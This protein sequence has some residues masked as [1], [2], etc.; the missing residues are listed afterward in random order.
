MWRLRS[1]RPWTHAST[2]EWTA[3]PSIIFHIFEERIEYRPLFFVEDRLQSFVGF[4]L[5]RLNLRLIVVEEGLQFR[6]QFTPLFRPQRIDF[7]ARFPHYLPELPLL[8][9]AEIKHLLE[10]SS[11]WPGTSAEV[12]ASEIPSLL[13]QRFPQPQIR[14]SGSDDGAEK[15]YRN[16]DCQ[17]AWAFFHSEFP[18]CSSQLPNS[19]LCICER[20]VPRFAES[21]SSISF[22]YSE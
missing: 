2:A 16:Q 22:S 6:L 1:F 4:I 10:T 3:A 20:L 7:F 12:L 5:D 11:P 15:K 8:I 18:S 14:S 21:V 9:I 19:P 13:I 17:C